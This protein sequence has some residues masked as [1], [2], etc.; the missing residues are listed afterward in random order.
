M[1][2]FT[3]SFN[4]KEHQGHFA[5]VLAH[6]VRNPLGNIRLS[7]DTLLSTV[8]E[9]SLNLYLNIIKRN[10]ERI[11]T[12]ITQLLTD[13]Y[14]N[15]TGLEEC[16][17]NELLDD[18]L[19]HVDDRLKLKNIKTVKHYSEVDYVI[20]LNVPRMKI[21]LTNIIINAIEAMTEGSGVLTL[22]T[23]LVYGKYVIEVND[24]GC[25]INKEN[26]A[27]MFKVSFTN[28]PGGLGLGLTIIYDIL[29]LNNVAINVESEEHTG[30]SFTLLFDKSKHASN[31]ARQAV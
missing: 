4:D 31:K 13:E 3:I 2:T 6:E 12:L 8:K 21:A 29:R 9:D 23:K 14:A 5:S 18:V 10:T 7:V 26:L 30:T 11:N 1:N 25:G 16:P 17:V 24:N 20:L 27:K 19:A 28:K 22:I 15:E